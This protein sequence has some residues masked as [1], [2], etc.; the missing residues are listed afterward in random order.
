MTQWAPACVC[1]CGCPLEADGWRCIGCAQAYDAGDGVLR[2]LSD[3]SRAATETF[4]SQYR[5][6]RK[7][8]GYRVLD[9]GYYRALPSVDAADPQH[10]VWEVR[11]ESFTR[12][13]QL[14]LSRFRRSSPAV[15]DLGAGNGWLSN[16]LTEAGCRTVAVDLLD[17]D[18]DGLGACR[19][20]DRAFARVQA[21]FDDL[22]FAAHQFD[23][24]V[25]NGSLHYAPDVSATLTRAASLLAPG[26]ALAV[27]DSPAFAEDTHG[28]LMCARNR[29]RFRRVYGVA[30]P[31][32]PGEGYVALAR[33]SSTARGLGLEPHFFESRGPLRW[34]AGRVI[35]RLRHGL[36]PPKFG[37]W[38]AT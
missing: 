30:S 13:R 4:L 27:V 8:D 26:G 5:T 28:Q 7:R 17:D 6:V 20:Y 2:W 10:V 34:A 16:R 24:V 32:Q 21:D 37:V 14:L 15:L 38:L 22:P 25:F 19:H 23:A 35:T 11:R 12:L 9:P 33:L 18:L 1:R 36:V 31:T 3:A 29:E